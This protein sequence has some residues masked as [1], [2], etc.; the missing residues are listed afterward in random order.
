[1]SPS[2]ADIHVRVDELRDLFDTAPPLIEGE[3]PLVAKLDHWLD[4]RI[5]QL[6]R[7]SL[8]A[9]HIRVAGAPVAADDAQAVTTRVHGHFSARAVALRHE[10]SHLF[11][12]GRISLLIGMGFLIL[13]LAIA[14]SAL[15]MLAAERHAM[16]IRESFII[17]GWVALWRPIEIFL[18]AW[19][20]VRVRIRQ[21]ERLARM[22]ISIHGT[23]LL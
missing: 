18:Y 21:F 23:G 1:M 12:E 16:L 4:E 7:G 2:P 17:V 6:P 5:R 11:R 14:E 3:Y 8:P 10:L 13:S 20:P 19:W 15:G 9:L 22:P